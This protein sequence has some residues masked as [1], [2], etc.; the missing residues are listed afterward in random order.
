MEV[1]EAAL[2][3]IK[4]LRENACSEEDDEDDEEDVDARYNIFFT[5]LGH[6]RS[7]SVDLI[8]V[9]NNKSDELVKDLSLNLEVLKLTWEH[10]FSR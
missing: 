2:G 4:K 1:A 3:A 5:S 6:L 8:V 10:D 7:C 9:L